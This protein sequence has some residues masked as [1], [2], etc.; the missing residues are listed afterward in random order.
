M[1]DHPFILFG[2]EHPTVLGSVVVLGAWMV[3]SARLGKWPRLV[4]VQ[5]VILAAALFACWPA[6]FVAAWATG[7]L[8]LEAVL[9]FHLCDL[10]ALCGGVALI[11]RWR[12]GAEFLYFWGVAGTLNGLITPTTTSGFPHPVF[13]AFFLLHGGVVLAALYVVLGTPMAPRPGAVWRMTACSLAYLA[14]IFLF[15]RLA[16]TNFAFTAFKP[17]TASLLDALGPWPW[18]V[19]SLIPI[20]IMS[21]IIFY[22]PFYIFRRFW[23]ESGLTSPCPFSTM[24]PRSSPS[25]P[26]QRP[27]RGSKL[28]D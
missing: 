24:A 16:G 15:N 21:F 1:P 11:R 4:R 5:E 22:S 6:K 13:I 10:A 2:R 8:D 3:V 9:P 12:L 27:V 19:L 20:G 25:D 14:V 18:Y 26:P 7:L 17:A 28:R 23:P